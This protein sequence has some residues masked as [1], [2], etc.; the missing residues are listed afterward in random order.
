[1]PFACGPQAQN[2]TQRAGSEVRLVRV[3]TIDGLNNAAASS[4]YS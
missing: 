4:E 3:R 2:K 1:M